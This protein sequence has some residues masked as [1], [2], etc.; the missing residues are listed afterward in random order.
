MRAIPSTVLRETCVLAS[1]AAL[2][3]LFVWPLPEKLRTHLTGDP[4][5]DAGAYVW[6][7][8]VFNHNLATGSSVLTTDRILTFANEVSLA[9]HNNSLILSVLAS[10]LVPFLGVIGAFNCALLMALLLNA[11]CMYRLALEE[12]AASVPAWLAGL[13]FGFS[14]FVS[15][16][17]EGHMSLATAFVLPLV[18]LTT[19]RAIRVA[20]PR[21]W[22][23][24]GASLALTAATDPYYL[25]FGTMIT[26]FVWVS[27]HVSTASV[28]RDLR[29]LRVGALVVGTFAFIALVWIGV[30]GGGRLALGGLSVGVRSPYTPVLVLTICALAWS[31]GRWPLRAA[32]DGDA[33]ASLRRV[34]SG[35]AVALI[36]LAPWLS[37]SAAEILER[38]GFEAVHWRSSPSGVDLASF[39]MPNPTHPVV[40]D[41]VE[42]WMTRARGDAFIE[43]V[44]SITV[45]LMAALLGLHLAGGS[46][47]RFWVAFAAFF[48]ALSIGPFLTIGGHATYV[49]GPWA[50]LRFLPGIGM[51]RSPSRFAVLVILG[52]AM[53][54]A[55]LAASA[56]LR[57]LRLPAFAVVATFIGIES[58]AFPRRLFATALPERYRVVAED[59]CD[60]AVLRLPVGITDGTRQRGRFSTETPFRQVFHGKR[61]LGGYLSRLDDDVVDRYEAHPTIRALMDLSEGKA[62]VGE[63]RRA[64]A[65]AAESLTREIGIGFVAI[66]KKDA[67]QDLRDFAQEAFRPRVVHKSWPFVILVPFG[68]EPCPGKHCGHVSTC[69]HAQPPARA[70]VEPS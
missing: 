45:A 10:P 70:A 18:V 46:A 2:V 42:P 36:L 49:P 28:T 61:L 24:A 5:G 47:P 4:A 57:R 20:T 64:A 59:R 1:Y 3:L 43:N 27:R 55:H 44:A 32:F 12:T 6:N 52:L 58:L 26:L 48:A 50:V 39:V 13:A 22:V 69:P 60:V 21:S 30:W 25:V 35:F 41:F 8:Y 31:Y 63:R 38:G 65:V 29:W 62:V 17:T 11:Y 33:A 54:L 7:A 34:S 68:H 56:P 23:L 19:R 15:A 16:R 67:S 53:C 66:S 51:V 37:A 9:L 14:P 40:R